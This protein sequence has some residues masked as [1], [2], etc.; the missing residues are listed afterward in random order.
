MES[1]LSYQPG[2]KAI[3]SDLGFMVLEWVI[4][5]C[6]GNPLHMFLDGNLFSPLQLKRTFFYNSALPFRF[7]EDEFA[8]TENCPWRKMVIQGLVHDENAYAVGGYSGHSGLFG[9]AEEV[10]MVADLLRSHFLGE[11]QDYLRPETV[12][13]FFSRQDLV[14]ESTWALGWDTPS[15]HNSSSGK[16]FSPRSVGHLGYTG[17]SLWIDLEKDIVVI[18]LSN[19]IH[20]SRKNEKI[21]AFRPIL[22]DTIMQEVVLYGRN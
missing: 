7:G 21:R 15:P 11:R 2:K 4:E 9:T 13:A 5:E 19:R 10:Y 1:P 3:Y 12:R 22:H 18:F 20:P 14:E 17:T 6:T 16:F 8:A